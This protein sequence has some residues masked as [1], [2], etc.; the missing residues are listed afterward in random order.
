MELKLRVD[1]DGA[2]DGCCCIPEDT[3]H[4]ITLCQK[5][6]SQKSS[7]LSI[8][9]KVTASTSRSVQRS[10]LSIMMMAQVSALSEIIKAV[11]IC[12]STII[13]SQ[14]FRSPRQLE[15]THES[16]VKKPAVVAL[17]RKPSNEFSDIFQEWR[18]G[19]NGLWI[20][21]GPSTC[22][23]RVFFSCYKLEDPSHS[24]PQRN[25]RS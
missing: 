7:L 4:W 3:K 5:F 23:F 16:W 14:N 6:A 2:G 13:N 21:A 11:Y 22:Y 15:I 24:G 20:L 8:G 25:R 12:T 9:W 18:I 17:T 1:I 10:I 19:E